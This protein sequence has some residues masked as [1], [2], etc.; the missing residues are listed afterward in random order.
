M[1]L[2]ELGQKYILARP[3]QSQKHLKAI[4]RT[5]MRFIEANGDVDVS[6]ITAEHLGRFLLTL[7]QY[8]R[9]SH[10]L[11]DYLVVLKAILKDGM[12]TGL[13]P[14]CP[15]F[16]RIPPEKRVPDAWTTEEVRR[17]FQVAA[18]LD[19]KVGT[20]PARIWWSSLLLAGYYTGLRLSALLDITWQQV[21]LADGYLWAR[22]NKNKLEQMFCIPSDLRNLLQQ[23]RGCPQEEVWAHPY[24]ACWPCKALRRIVDAA[25]ISSPRTRHGQLFQKMRRTCISLIAMRD[26]NLATRVAGHASPDTT[27]RHY[28]DPRMLGAIRPVVPPIQ[29]SFR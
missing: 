24:H 27:I 10:S 6:T 13:I 1:R 25:G 4:N 12:E 20:V 21:D 5:I 7:K 26:L 9:S 3:H 29:V 15:R 14:R 22:S 18:S 8:V 23:M 11:R 19:G 28:V 17:L 2:S 16:P